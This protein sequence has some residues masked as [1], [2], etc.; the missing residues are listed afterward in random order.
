MF[1]AEAE[2]SD[3]DEDTYSENCSPNLV[4]KTTLHQASALDAGCSARLDRTPYWDGSPFHSTLA[5]GRWK[6]SNYSTLTR[7]SDAYGLLL[8]L[9]WPAPGIPNDRKRH[10]DFDQPKKDVEMPATKDGKNHD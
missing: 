10:G 7:G 6:F 5:P 8:C 3:G 2:W 4:L 9:F 1:A